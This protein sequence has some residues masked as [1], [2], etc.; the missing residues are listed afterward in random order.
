[1]AKLMKRWL[2]FLFAAA[3]FAVLHEGMHALMASLFG[4]YESF[5][6]R[7]FGLEV[8]F[9]TPVEDR[10]GVEWAFIS[11]VS[12]LLTLLLG[13]LLLI[14]AGRLS[15]LHSEF[16][17]ASFF[18]LTLLLLLLDPLN[19]S[20]GPFIYGGDANGI[21]FGLGVS[22]YL[23]QAFFFM[24]LLVNRELVAQKLLPAYGVKTDNFILK[25]WI[26]QRNLEQLN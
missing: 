24:V 9:V 22:R 17:V 8:N 13:Y 18:Y 11:G 25:S 20:I 10:H 14:L 1:M 21:A 19:L 5:H 12:N 23:I 7:P 26:P 15:R 3:I 16:L 2:Y 6:I 4:E